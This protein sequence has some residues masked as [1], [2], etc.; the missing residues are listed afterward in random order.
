MWL[1]TEEI[2]DACLLW[3]TK[4]L[5]SIEFISKLKIDIL[6]CQIKYMTK[7]F[8]LFRCSVKVTQSCFKENTELIGKVKEKNI[9]NCFCCT[10]SFCS[11]LPDNWRSLCLKLYSWYEWISVGQPLIPSHLSAPRP[12][13]GPLGECVPWTYWALR[14]P[15]LTI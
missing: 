11:L 15:R 2:T 1:I 5:S 10:G 14:Q 7:W 13:P 3:Q 12:A 6:Y 8:P 9:D 4:K